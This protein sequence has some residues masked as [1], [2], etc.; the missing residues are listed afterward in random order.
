MCVRANFLSATG[1]V[2]QDALD[3]TTFVTNA[4]IGGSV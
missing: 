3:A 2:K 4:V 1:T